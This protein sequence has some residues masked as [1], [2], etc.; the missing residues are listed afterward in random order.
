MVR[1][2]G[3]DAR[4]AEGQAELKSKLCLVMESKG[5]VWHMALVRS[6]PIRHVFVISVRK[7]RRER[8]EQRL[9]VIRGLVRSWQG[10][11]GSK[12][13]RQELVQHGVVAAECRLRM[14]EIGCFLSHRRIWEQVRGRK[15][16]PTLIL[17]DDTTFQ[18]TVATSAA[19]RAALEQL[20][21]VRWDVLLLGRNRR[22]MHNR[23]KVSRDL[24]VPR[25]WCGLF[26]YVVNGPRAAARLLRLSGVKPVGDIPVDTLLSRAGA[27]NEIR[28]VACRE[29]LSGFFTWGSDTRGIE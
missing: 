20:R 29:S 10:V 22:R 8:A 19:V 4:C 25:L 17:E 9:S 27:R 7:E 16:G 1:T 15:L 26:C 12:L 2:R 14:G 21:G 28:V 18:P 13:N 24:V 3:A 6:F 23:S 11:L 5:A